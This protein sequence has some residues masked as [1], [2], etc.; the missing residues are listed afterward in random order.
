M[1]TLRVVVS[2]RKRFADENFENGVP[3]VLPLGHR[4]Y[5]VRP[6]AATFSMSPTGAAASSFAVAAE[7]QRTA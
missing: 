2:S 1:L 7:S 6:S 3:S 5:R 4:Q